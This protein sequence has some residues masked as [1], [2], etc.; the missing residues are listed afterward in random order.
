MAKDGYNAFMKVLPAYAQHYVADL[1]VKTFVLGESEVAPV[2]PTLKDL[3][4]RYW[5]EGHQF[6]NHGFGEAG[7]REEF[8]ERWKLH[9]VGTD[10]Q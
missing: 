4:W 5:W 1:N 3:A 10:E 7:A 6:A 9:G 8:E 2:M